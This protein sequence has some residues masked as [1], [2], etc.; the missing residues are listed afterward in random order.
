MN[1]TRLHSV[2]IVNRCLAAHHS[3]QDFLLS[4]CITSV[5][6]GYGW[7]STANQ[8]APQVKTPTGQLPN[9]PI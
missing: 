2:Q 5:V 9:Y 8:P 6:H 1:V 3:P 4:Q 7:N